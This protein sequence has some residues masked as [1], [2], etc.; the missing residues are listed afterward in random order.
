MGKVLGTKSYELVENVWLLLFRVVVGCTMLSHGIP[1][2][3]SLFARGPIEFPDPFGVGATFTLILVV[4]AEAFCS[5]L[6]ALGLFTRLA[7]IP[8]IIDMAVAFLVIHAA[9]PFGDKE[10]ALLYLVIY[11]TI[12]VFGAGSFSFDRLVRKK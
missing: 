3:L 4:F 11:V 10:M 7:T 1:K 5:V 12:L 9:D 8:L 2:L 6:I